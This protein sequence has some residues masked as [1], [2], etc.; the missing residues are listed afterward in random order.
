MPLHSKHSAGSVER[1]IAF[2][3]MLQSTTPSVQ[4]DE[5]GIIGTPGT[6]DDAEPAPFTASL[7]E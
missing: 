7:P 5:V 1:S 2:F 3:R 4:T 6:E